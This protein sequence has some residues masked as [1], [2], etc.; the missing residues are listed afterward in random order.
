M[1]L[2]PHGHL[3]QVQRDGPSVGSYWLHMSAVW[4]LV[5]LRADVEL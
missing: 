4:P 2:L 1:L 5:Q 3:F